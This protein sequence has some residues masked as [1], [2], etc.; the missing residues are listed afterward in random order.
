[1]RLVVGL[2][3]DV[4]T[5]SAVEGEGDG[6]IGHNKLKDGRAQ[7]HENEPSRP[8]AQTSWTFRTRRIPE[9]D[10]HLIVPM[11]AGHTSSAAMVVVNDQRMGIV[12]CEQPRRSR[13]SG[14]HPR[15]E[16]RELNA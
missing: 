4:Q 10:I 9:R 14:W 15:V 16:H 3:R 8:P 12:H 1:M 6:H 2:G 7:L 11:R 5:K 13:G